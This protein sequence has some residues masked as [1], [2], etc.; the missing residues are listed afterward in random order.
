MERK[1]EMET[2]SLFLDDE[3]FP[4]NDN[5]NWKIARSCSEA[6]IL[7]KNFGMPS[8][9]SFDHD[10]GDESING[11]GY[12]FAKHICDLDM[13]TDKKFPVG[14][15]YYVHSQNPVGRDNIIGYLENYLK[16]KEKWNGKNRV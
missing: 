8:Y 7:I 10:L 14:F 1:T 16:M 12:K 4:P 5:R 9:I 11:S 2:W 3:R 15:D 13:L 6:D